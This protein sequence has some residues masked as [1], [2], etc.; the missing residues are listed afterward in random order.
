MRLPLGLT[1]DAL[2]DAMSEDDPESL[3]SGLRMRAGTGRSWPRLHS[4]RPRLRWRATTKFGHDALAMFFTRDGLEQASRPEVADHHAGR[5][6]QAGVRRVI[7]IG[8]GI[9]SDSLAF[10]RAGLEVVALDID[11][12]T[13]AVAQA[14]LGGSRERDLRRCE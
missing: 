9:G 5:F 8:C 2:R 13:A 1:E 10:A 6:V 11:P 12:V 7:D 4:P 3:G 14:N